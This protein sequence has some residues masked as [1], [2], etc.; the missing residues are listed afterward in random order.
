MIRQ[1]FTD[2]FARL[3]STTRRGIRPP[4]LRESSLRSRIMPTPMPDQLLLPLQDYADP[5]AREHDRIAPCVDVGDWVAKYQLLAKG[6]EPG[7][8]RLHAPTSGTVQ[9]I[10]QIP[11][12]A[13]GQRSQLAIRLLTDTD[14]R[15]LP[16]E[17]PSDYR[18]LAPEQLVQLIEEAGICGLGGAGYP[19]ARKIR[20]AVEKN[21][22]TLIINGVECEPYISCDEALLRERASLTVKG[23]ELL[24]AACL[25]D[26][27]VIVIDNAM[28]AARKALTLA[29]QGSSISL[30]V[31]H[32]RYPAGDERQL[33][34]A[35]CRREVPGEGHPPDVGVLVQ[36]IGTAVA[37]Y[38]AIVH[39]KPCIS[40]IVTLTGSA[41]LTPKNFD[42]PIG[43]PVQH[44]LKLCGVDD[45][46]HEF[47]IRGGS[48]MGQYLLEQSAP[49]EKT[50]NC[51]IASNSLEIPEWETEQ[52]C[53][54]CGYCAQACPAQL[55][56]QQ[57]LAS[58]RSEER[59]QTLALGLDD[60]IECGACAVVCP[61]RI[62]LVSYYRA[63]KEIHREEF[64]SHEQSRHWQARFQYHQYR[65]KK[66]QDRAQ[67]RKA[68]EQ[69]VKE[70]QGFSRDQARMEISAAVERVRRR[71]QALAGGKDPGQEK[72]Q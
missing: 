27:C 40:R 59:Q 24:Q 56:P 26:D 43:T 69:T 17:P 29:L 13:I 39:A 11:A 30:R 45:K 50:T 51:I 28:P 2:L 61:S 47:T 58:I 16:L 65:L 1:A 10:E 34:K 70:A 63:A 55:Q 64:T 7:S 19:T 20:D 41:L 46:E 49:I 12:A 71:R 5:L 72:S 68:V 21:V 15:E 33:V 25:A 57:L 14:E 52:A 23:A 35:I 37:V 9:A 18:A 42:V 22:K 66:N 44:L 54:R 6:K 62:P 36:N 48:L 60:C 32:R 67:P 3:G 4:T 53:I 38:E 8:L 31:V